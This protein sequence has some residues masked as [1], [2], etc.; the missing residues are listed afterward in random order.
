M[1]C[2]YWIFPCYNEEEC[3]PVSKEAILVKFHSFLEKGLIDESSKLV[4]VDD[5]S[6][7]KT[8][9][10]IEEFA[11]EDG[12]IVGLKLSRNKGHQFAVE[13]GLRYAHMKKASFTITMDV[14]LQDDIEAVEQMILE[15]QKGFDVVYGVRND[16]K[17]DSFFKKATANSYY[18]LMKRLGVELIEN[19]ADFRLLSFRAVEALL[20]YNEANLFL[21]GLVPQIGFPSSKVE[22]KRLPRQQGK[23][24][25]PLSKMVRLALDGLTAFSDKPLALIGKL[26]WF[27]FFGSALAMIVFMILHLTNVLPY[28][29][30]YYLFPFMALLLGI[31]LI[32]LGI[33]ATYLAKINLEV[34]KR[35]HYFI[36]KTTDEK[37]S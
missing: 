29:I 26:G 30:F 33:V 14:D 5:G 22:Y 27:F 21:R 8:W 20:S 1:D 9:S 31:L 2:L 15:H 16:R 23:T 19:A 7:D 12:H 3:L 28:S 36:E 13:A 10:I 6:K 24:H 17:S 37:D 32:C 35:P 11:K 34:R 4:F 18:K 25:Y